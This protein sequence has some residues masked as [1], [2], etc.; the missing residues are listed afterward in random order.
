MFMEIIFL[1]PSAGS[2]G[3]WKPPPEESSN[4]ITIEVVAT[5][6]CP[7]GA[8]GPPA[9]GLQNNPEGYR[10]HGKARHIACEQVAPVTL[11]E[12]P[13]RSCP[14]GVG[15]SLSCELRV[16]GL[17]WLG[18]VPGGTQMPPSGKKTQ[19]G[20]LLSQGRGDE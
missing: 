3:G 4:T 20:G 14:C 19:L 17:S 13:L 12:Q 15:Q 16:C 2:L 7:P 8:C 10:H 5:A 9:L 18:K 11:S 6:A 1:S